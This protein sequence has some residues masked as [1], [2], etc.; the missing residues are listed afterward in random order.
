[1][2]ISVNFVECRQILCKYGWCHVAVVSVILI[3]NHVVYKQKKKKSS[4]KWISVPISNV[5]GLKHGNVTTTGSISCWPVTLW[6]TDISCDAVQY[7]IVSLSLY[8]QRDSLSG[9]INHTEEYITSR[10]G[11][12]VERFR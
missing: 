3:D 10:R 5:Y 11:E 7:I 8:K 4:E 12:R 2:F 9:L 1:M 6:F